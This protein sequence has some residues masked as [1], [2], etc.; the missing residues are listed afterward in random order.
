LTRRELFYPGWRAAINNK[1][2]SPVLAAS[3]FQGIDLAAGDS[4]IV[5]RYRPSYFNW[6]FGTALLAAAWLSRQLVRGS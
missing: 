5:F 6:T 4:S 3:I 2:V 1:R